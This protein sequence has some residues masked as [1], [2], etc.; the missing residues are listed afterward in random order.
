MK[1]K[2]IKEKRVV[3]KKKKAYSKPAI[4][5]QQKLKSFLLICGDQ[6]PEECD[7]GIS[8]S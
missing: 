7:A 8:G 2:T 4:I 6:I 5:E 1:E 3:K